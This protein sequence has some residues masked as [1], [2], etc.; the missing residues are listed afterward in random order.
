VGVIPAKGEVQGQP[1]AA[2]GFKTDLREGAVGL[3][4]IL[5]QGIA[6]IAP[7]FAILASFVFTVSLAGIN[8]PWAYLLAGLVLLLMAI[9]SSQLAK[10]LP[11]A[12]GWYTWIARA[13]NP[14]AGFFAG[15]IF[16]IW[17]PPVAAFVSSYLAKTVLEPE[18]KAQY[19]V[20]IPWWLW[21]IAIVGLVTFLSYRGIAISERMLLITGLV[22]IVIMVAL[23]ISGLISP[24]RGGFSLQPFNVGHFGDAPNMFLAVVF[25]IFGFSGWEAT[26]PLAEE[27]R[28]PRRYIVL[29]LIGSVIVLA[30]YFVFVTWGYL[31]GIGVDNVDSIP[32][33]TAFPVF[34]LATRVWGDAWVLLLFALLNSAIAVSIACF[35]GGTRT[36]YGMGRTGVL[37]KALAQVSPT[38]KTPDKAIAVEAGVCAF[39]F[40]LMLVFSVEDVFFTWA[41][42]ITL[43]LILMYILANIGVIKYYLTERRAQFNPLT[44]L[45]LPIVAS[46]AV[47][48][49]GYKSVVPLP[50]APV[51]YAPLILIG[52]LLLGAA[53]LVWHNARGNREWLAKAQMAMEDSGGH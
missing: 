41:L 48:Y 23:A 28:N 1:A 36:W 5:M 47:G 24:G 13:L 35:N 27:S 14:Q 8:T 30:V 11:S 7:G 37:P 40:L 32:K 39:A 26:A 21:V 52:W 17:L 31:V 34:T 25:S 15:W 50:A 2:E 22:E 38:R 51:K 45:V 9:T 29:G 19:G 42:T 16:S 12:G 46:I 43:G 33:A 18:L 53:V 3:P 20:T 6:T 49:V 4:G 44:H 10:E